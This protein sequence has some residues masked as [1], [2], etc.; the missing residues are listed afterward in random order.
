VEALLPFVRQCV[1]GDAWAHARMGACSMERLTCEIRLRGMPK[2]MKGGGVPG[3][4]GGCDGMRRDVGHVGRLRKDV[5]VSCAGLA[6]DVYRRIFYHKLQYARTHARI[7]APSVTTGN[8]PSCPPH[9]S[10]FNRNPHHASL[11]IA[12]TLNPHPKSSTLVGKA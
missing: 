7:V 3:A 4:S 11:D 8:L 10:A 1:R 9:H 6:H 12:V 5:E 2:D